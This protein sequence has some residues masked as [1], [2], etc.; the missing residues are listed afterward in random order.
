MQTSDHLEGLDKG[1]TRGD[2]ATRQHFILSQMKLKP[3]L[4]DSESYGGAEKNSDHK[5]AVAKTDLKGMFTIWSK[6]PQPLS[7]IDVSKFSS[8]AGLQKE[9]TEA[10]ATK[11]HNKDMN[12]TAKN[13]MNHL[14]TCLKDAAAET[15]GH[16]QTT[17]SS[18]Q[19]DPG[20]LR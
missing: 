5:I 1:S 10:V 17:H 15:V 16:A 3:L 6:M 8:D 18:H 13:V 2:Q 7:R 20:S 9:L 12:G 14:V 4:S 11:M 19:Y